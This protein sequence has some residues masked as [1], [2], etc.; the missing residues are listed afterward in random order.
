MHT[1]LYVICFFI[2]IM[3]P[4]QYYK[5]VAYKLSENQEKVNVI[6]S[7]HSTYTTF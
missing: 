3:S 6:F 1:L 5:T 2:I 4:R 7:Y